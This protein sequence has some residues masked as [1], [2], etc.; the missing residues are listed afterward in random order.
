[1]RVDDRWK[2]AKEKKLCFHCLVNNHQEGSVRERNNVELM[3]AREI[4]TDSCINHRKVKPTKL[5]P[6]R[7]PQILLCPLQEPL[8]L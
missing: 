1:M 7:N 6:L 8:Q 5:L 3:A 2:I 4:T